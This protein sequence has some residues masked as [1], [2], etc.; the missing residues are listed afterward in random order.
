MT[1]TET[2]AEVKAEVKTKAK[3]I[4]TLQEYVN[5]VPPLSTEE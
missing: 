2:E 1:R 5:L 3:T 4:K